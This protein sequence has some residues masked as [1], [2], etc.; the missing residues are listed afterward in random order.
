MWIDNEE[1]V[2]KI[3]NKE[4]DYRQFMEVSENKER[5]HVSESS[6]LFAKP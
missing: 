2:R 1:I 3:E 4:I 5:P 6:H